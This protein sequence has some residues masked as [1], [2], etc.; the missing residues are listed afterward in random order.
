MHG[1]FV[2]VHYFPLNLSFVGDSE[3]MAEYA[4]AFSHMD[5]MSP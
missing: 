1:A 4:A 2:R 3:K 5:Y